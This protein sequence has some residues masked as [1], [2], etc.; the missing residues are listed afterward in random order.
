MPADMGTFIL[1]YLPFPWNDKT[2]RYRRKVGLSGN[3]HLHRPFVSDSA[4]P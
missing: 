2:V 1:L 3:P 4:G